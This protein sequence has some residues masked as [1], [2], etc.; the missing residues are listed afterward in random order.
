MKTES[1]SLRDKVLA[2]SGGANEVWGKVG[3]ASLT[4]WSSCPMFAQGS[5]GRGGDWIIG[6]VANFGFQSGYH[7]VRPAPDVL[8]P[9]V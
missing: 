5:G 6:R 4:Y 1:L 7:D 3:G 9:A 8:S 2:V